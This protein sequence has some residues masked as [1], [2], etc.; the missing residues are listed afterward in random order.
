MGVLGPPGVSGTLDEWLDWQSGLNPRTIELGLDRVQRV[1]NRLGAPAPAGVV[2]SVAGT[3]GKGSSVALIEAVAREAGYRVGSYTSP[4]LLRYNERIRLDGLAAEDSAICRAFERIEQHRGAD[5]LTY[6][7]FGTLAALLLF[8]DQALDLAVLEVGLGGRLDAVNIIDADVA[9]VT[10]IA[11]DHTDWLGDTLEQIGE[12]KAGI[13]RPGRPAVFAAP[14]MPCSVARVAETLGAQ[15]H[16]L[17][18]AYHFNQH[19]QSW[20]WIGRDKRRS[21]L[22]IPGLRGAVQ[23]Q[24]AAGVLQ[25]FECLRERLPVDQAA[26]R[27]GLLKARV[28]GRFQVLQYR[29]RWVLDVAHNPQAAGALAAQLSDMFVNGQVHAV[30]GM[31]RDKDAQAVFCKLL[32]R[33]DNWH[34]AGLGLEQR[35]ASAVELR[36]SL[37]AGVRQQASCHESVAACLDDLEKTLGKDDLVLVFGSF[38]TVGEAMQWLE[39]RQ[40]Q[41]VNDIVIQ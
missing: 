39:T 19:P 32:E 26:I 7:E 34:L 27:N 20:D 9:L 40:N 37:P 21:A 29:C 35:G 14:D 10:G 4:H 8:A 16:R 18:D 36:G 25:V 24:N 30:V 11:L 15:L 28:A 12:E 1:W 5:R 38:V 17:G 22:P 6:F 23:L 3:N 33:V 31:L 2:V 41:A 13:M